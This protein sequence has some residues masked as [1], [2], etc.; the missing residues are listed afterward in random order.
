MKI[1]EEN[2]RKLVREKAK[3]VLKERDTLLTEDEFT[4]EEYKE[5]VDIIRQEL[6]RTFHTFYRKRNFWT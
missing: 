2:L 6:V 3:S 4:D 5:I 1:R